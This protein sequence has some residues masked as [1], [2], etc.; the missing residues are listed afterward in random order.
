MSL[1]GMMSMVVGFGLAIVAIYWWLNR[2]V[3]PR[4]GG[5]AGRAARQ[6]APRAGGSAGGAAVIERSRGCLRVL[7]CLREMRRW[8]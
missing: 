6:P 2:T 5:R 7:V 8:G 4:V 3:V 1:K